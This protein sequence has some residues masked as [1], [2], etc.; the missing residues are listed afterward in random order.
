M[1]QSK[2][3]VSGKVV[4][5]TALM[6]SAALVAAKAQ[7]ALA[8]AVVDDQQQ[9]QAGAAP[10]DFN[11]PAQPL[12]Q[13]LTQF[14]RQ[15]G[16]QVA[17]DAAAV[18]GKSSGGVYGMMSAQS[19]LQ[20]VLAGT[21]ITYR[22]T[23]PT[24]VSVVGPAPGASG[25]LQLDPVQVQGNLAPSQAEIGNLPPPFAGGQVARG[26][27]VGVLGNRDYMDTPFSSTVYTERTIQ[28]QQALTLTEVVAV[29]PTIRSI[30]PQ[31]SLDDRLIIRGFQVF[32]RDMGMNGLYGINPEPSIGMVGIERVEVFRGPTAMLNGMA[33][34][35]AIGGT[36]NFVTKRA[37]D[38]GIYQAT[39]R[40]MSNL[41]F[42]GALDVGKRFGPNKELGLRANAAYS[43]GNTSVSNNTDDLLQLTLGADYRSE[44]TRMDADFGYQKRII[45]GPRLGTF[46]AA[47][48]NVPPA[49]NAQNNYN[50][51]W[52]FFSFG[53]LYGMVRLE[54]D[55]SRNF[56]GYI[57]AGGRNST[58]DSLTTISTLLNTQGGMSGSSIRTLA[59]L[60]T[61]SADVGVRG[62]FETGSIRHEAAANV[63]YQKELSGFRNTAGFAP[64]F[65][66]NIYTPQVVA[67]PNVPGAALTPPAP[68]S[69][70]VM[71]SVGLVDSLFMLDD[72]VQII[73][74]IRNQRIQLS[75]FSPITGLV[76]P[77][78]PG[79]DQGAVT[80]TVSMVIR[81]WKEF[82]LYGN[83]IE[84]LERGPIAGAGTLNAGQAFAPFVSRQFEVG[85]KL[86]LGNF[87]ATLSAFQITRP[88]SFTSAGTFTVDGQQRNSGIEFIVFGEPLP[89][90]KPLGGF[91]VLDPV[92]TNTAG[93]LNNGKTA[94]GAARFQ[95]NLGFDWD[96]PFL[97]GVGVSA[98]ILYTGQA[99]I[100]P[101]NTQV[102]PAWARVDLGASYT[103]ERPD[104][105]PLT[106]RAN[107]INVGNANYWM[108]TNGFMTE[109]LPRTFMLSLTADF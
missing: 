26:G 93:G 96:M 95:A 88:S 56:T 49:P 12:A 59:F 29:D 14:G 75:N 2:R 103:F 45:N 105:K 54:H 53:D 33:A 18:A 55:F 61:F 73:A 81:P 46:L 15:S 76:T 72:R 20:Q 99:Y 101:A 64:A 90:F 50:Q 6:G 23:S 21:G 86:D 84:A 43:G 70:T 68:T 48:V 11:I 85:A 7:D 31:G 67:A 8:Q 28:N 82:A 36:I 102:A 80:P 30:Y 5:L 52:E 40:Y 100:D 58:R 71:T 60:D 69:D 1:S 16:L 13:A 35:G 66:N 98:R 39:A 22:F 4:L 79:S 19:A 63:T 41:Q 94:P 109:G 37:P 78:T 91:T 104:G 38:E 44:N 47:G 74:G 57:K 3:R 24:A 42:G 108:A 97:K 62:K 106:L 92:L 77:A 32:V 25:A 17:V 27:R 83:Y 87:G 9:A 51:P 34:N 10:V 65:A 107:A 89:G